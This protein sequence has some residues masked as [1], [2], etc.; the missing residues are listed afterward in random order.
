MR[1][2]LLTFALILAFASFANSQEKEFKPEVKVGGTLYTGWEYN[3]G[4][5]EF[6]NSLDLSAPDANQPF[7]YAPEKN[8]F[9]TSKNSFYLERAYINVMA[10]LTPELKARFTPDIYSYKDNSGIT[11]FAY[12]VKFAWA[13][14]TPLT[15]DD[16]ISLS[17]M[18]GVIPTL[19]T[20]QADKYFGYRGAM[21]TLTNYAFTSAASVNATTGAVTRTTSSFFPTADLGLSS[22]FVFPKKYADLNVAILNGNGFRNL[23][24]DN[25]FKDFMASAFIYPLAGD[26]SKKTEAAKKS[27]KNRISGV[28]DLTFGGYAYI[29]KLGSGEGQT[30]KSRFGGLGHFKYSFDRAGF[31]RIGA[32]IGSLSNQV[33]NMN[34]LDSNVT[35]FGI[36]TWLEF[37]PPVEE[38]KEKL[39]LVARFDTYNPNTDAPGTNPTGFN[40]DNAQ[41]NLLMVGLF[42]KPA[43]VLTL[44]LNYQM[45]SYEKDF[46]VKYDGTPT[47]SVSRLFFNTIL[48]F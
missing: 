48:E 27:G 44:G 45:Q 33:S 30:A 28:S 39:S 6:I 43:S 26:I 2:T 7:G 8:Q 36:S 24:F 12:Q 19:W 3:A 41:Q 40:A 29:G 9:E 13:E 5:A 14:Y 35:G 16:G 37:N 1:K 34:N 42:F 32:E 18:G 20:G 25:R 10:K 31:I 46:A 21:P 15:T 23:T 17:F 4:D 47:S 38:L 22:K 11:Q